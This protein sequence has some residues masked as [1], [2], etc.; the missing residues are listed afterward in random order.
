MDDLAP[1][2]VALILGADIDA[3]VS[4]ETH[5]KYD[6][7]LILRKNYGLA[8]QIVNRFASSFRNYQRLDFGLT[9]Y[10]NIFKNANFIEICIKYPC[11]V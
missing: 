7:L 10:Q 6:K 1:N 5:M 2:D 4:I 11:H 3:D 8:P 9:N